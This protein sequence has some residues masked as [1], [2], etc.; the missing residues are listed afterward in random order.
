MTE[1]STRTAPLSAAELLDPPRYGAASISP[2]G[3]RIAFLSPWRTRLNVWVA[4]IPEG[5]SP[6][7]VDLGSARC[8]TADD[9]RPILDY[10]WTG[11][12]D[13]LLYLQDTD[14][15]ENHHVFRVDLDAWE[16]DTAVPAVDLTPFPGRACSA[17]T[18]CSDRPARS[19][20][21]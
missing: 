11:D 19:S 13:V 2:D 8:V 16:S 14:G 15:D 21:R 4:D 10:R 18:R 7:D 12:P 9:D 5:G 3:R 17:C 20:C 6:H 1:P